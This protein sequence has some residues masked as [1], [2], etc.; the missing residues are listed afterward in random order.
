MSTVPGPPWKQAHTT[1]PCTDQCH[2]YPHWPD[3][4][5]FQAVR[6]QHRLTLDPV[7]DLYVGMCTCGGLTTPQWDANAVSEAY[8]Q[9]AAIVQHELRHPK[10]A[11]LLDG[12]GTTD[13]RAALDEAA[14]GLP[15]DH[16]VRLLWQR[17][18]Q[19][20]TDG[21]AECLPDPW[22]HG[23]ENVPHCAGHT[24]PDEAALCDGF[25]ATRSGR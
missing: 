15:A 10:P 1:G 14:A 13:M 20:L 3:D 4:P 5:L 25:C 6:D 2:D 8:D 16:P 11:D 12:L 24:D 22:D 9:H 17:L 7:G 23:H 18:D 21:G 19:V